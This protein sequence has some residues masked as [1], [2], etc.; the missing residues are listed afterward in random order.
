MCAAHYVTSG[1]ANIVIDVL[2]FSYKSTAFDVTSLVT[3]VVKCVFYSSF[4]STTV[5][6]LL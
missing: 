5:R 3:C 2:G 1:I 4:V 6:K